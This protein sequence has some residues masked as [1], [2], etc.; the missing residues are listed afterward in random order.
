MKP[1]KDKTDKIKKLNARQKLFVKE[2][3]NTWNATIAYKKAYNVKSEDTAKAS[4]CRL[5][6]NVYIQDYISKAKLNIEQTTGLSKLKIVQEWQKQAL[7]NP[8]TDLNVTWFEPKE[9]QSLSSEIKACIKTIK[10]IVK[11]VI[12]KVKTIKK[13]EKGND[14]EVESTRKLSKPFVEVEFYDKQKALQEIA[15]LMGYYATEKLDLTSKG[16]SINTKTF[17]KIGETQIEI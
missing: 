10:Q 5:L 2:Y 6:T 1:D 13:D 14:V 15:K 9:F 12:V 16:E 7:N 4:G 17:I 11:D 8:A 3:L